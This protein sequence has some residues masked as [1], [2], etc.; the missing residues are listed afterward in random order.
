MLETAQITLSQARQ[1]A[2]AEIERRIKN[3]PCVS[4]YSDFSPVDLKEENERFWTFVSGSE[5]WYEDGGTPAAVYASVDKA[6][7]H[8]WSREEKEQYYLEQTKPHAA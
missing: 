3:S 6:D 4:Q 7:G 1:I 8:I 2:A 5:Q